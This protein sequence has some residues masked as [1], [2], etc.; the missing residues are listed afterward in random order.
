MN[1]LLKLALDL[2]PLLIFFAANAVGGIFTAE[3]AWEKM[4]AGASLVQ[5]YTGL[6][7]QGPDIAQQINEGL[8]RI[9]AR[10]GFANLDAAVG[11]RSRR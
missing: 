4:S 6:I 5:L 9:L 2:G 1:P 11:H 10:E 8:S 7:Y 3:D